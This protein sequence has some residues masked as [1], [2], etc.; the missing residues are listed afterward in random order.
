M[1]NQQILQLIE[2]RANEIISWLNRRQQRS[3]SGR[4]P[5]LINVELTA[6]MLALGK[7][8]DYTKLAM[9]NDVLMEAEKIE[10]LAKVQDGRF[11]MGQNRPKWAVVN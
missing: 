9:D 5:E 2:D 3:L 8:Y 10:A 6:W 11:Q 1:T 7:I 4:K